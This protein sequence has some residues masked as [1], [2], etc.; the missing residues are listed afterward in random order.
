M[1]DAPLDELLGENNVFHIE[2][3]KSYAVLVFVR[4]NPD[5]LFDPGIRYDLPA[6]HYET[7]RSPVA[8]FQRPVGFEKRAG[9]AYAIFREVTP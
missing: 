7:Y 3:D 8:L 1:L 6:A 5:Q 4:C 9:D 2:I